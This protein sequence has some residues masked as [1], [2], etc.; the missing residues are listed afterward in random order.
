MCVFFIARR[1][2]ER[3]AVEV[4][5]DAGKEGVAQFFSAGLGGNVG[6]DLLMVWV[7]G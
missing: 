1:D 7:G 2:E 3:G 4:G 5:Q 6:I